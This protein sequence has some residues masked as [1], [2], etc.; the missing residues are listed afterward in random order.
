MTLSRC[1]RPAKRL[2]PRGMNLDSNFIRRLFGD[3][4]A[5]AYEDQLARA[6]RDGR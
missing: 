5:R 1:A 2:R 6:K 4:F 3:E